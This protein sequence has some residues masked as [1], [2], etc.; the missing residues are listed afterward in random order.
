MSRQKLRLALASLALAVSAT[1]SSAAI[2]SVFD[3]GASSA[4]VAASIIAP[5]TSVL[6]QQVP[7]LAQQ[8]FDERQ[9]V[10]LS[11]D[12]AVDGA[13][14]AAGT[15]VDSHM[16][17]LNKPDAR[18]GRLTHTGVVWGFSGTILGVMSDGFGQLEAGSTSLLGA[19]GT[20]YP[21]NGFFARGMESNDSYAINGN[22]LTVNMFVRQPG[23]WIRVI[24]ASAVP[25]PVPAA[26]PL[27]LLALGGL[28]LVKRRRKQTA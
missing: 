22:E 21:G 17:F 6:D 16:I 19:I 26:M 1:A 27:L 5:P 13:S 15:R 10:I 23:D 18:D 24:T 28:A 4:G 11:A 7:N 9:G 2:I 3:A 25:V 14:I 8:G 20:I 12:L